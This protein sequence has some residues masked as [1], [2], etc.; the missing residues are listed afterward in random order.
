MIPLKIELRGILL[1]GLMLVAGM[2]TACGEDPEAEVEDVVRP[3]KLMTIDSGGDGKTREYPGTVSATQSV[4]LGFE[5]AGKIV[6]LPI[7]DGLAVKKAHY[8][9]NWTSR[10]SSPRANQLKRIARRPI[11][12]MNV[13]SA[14][15]S[16]G[17]FP[18]RG[19]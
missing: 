11:Q 13:P 2:L 17:R 8:W 16:R 19:R 4:E 7:S 14:F 5:V 10:T 15:L 1:S 3:V 18:G 12:P 9:G 6:E